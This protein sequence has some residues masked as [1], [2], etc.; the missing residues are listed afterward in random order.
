[1]PPRHRFGPAAQALPHETCSICREIPDRSRSFDKGGETIESTIP[2]AV[3][4]LQVVG[5]PFFTKD[6]SHSHQC[7]LR[8]P[9]CGTYYDWSFEYEYLAGGS[10]DD[11]I[12]TR[13]APD[14]G[15]RRA[16]SVVE[17]IRGVQER[18]EAEAPIH[19]RALLDS[20]DEDQVAKAAGWLFMAQSDGHDLTPYLRDLLTAWQR[21]GFQ[22]DDATSLNLVFF[23]YGSRSRENLS[24]LRAAIRAAG[25]EGRPEMVSLLQSCESALDDD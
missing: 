14:E 5:A 17:H 11:L 6:Y 4:R 19:V 7:L 25:L 3:E 18:F 22:S 21:P 24:G 20:N 16:S 13:L 10:E 9:Q 23:V 8:C 1:M 15:A 12:V 2:A